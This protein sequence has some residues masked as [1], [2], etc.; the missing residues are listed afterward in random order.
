M[1]LNRLN[2]LFKLDEFGLKESLF[3]GLVNMYGVDI[4]T[5]PTS[6]W[7]VIAALCDNYL[8]PSGYLLGEIRKES[9]RNKGIK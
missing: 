4:P 5:C 6:P 7:A 2:E 1:E 9:L 3:E 8:D